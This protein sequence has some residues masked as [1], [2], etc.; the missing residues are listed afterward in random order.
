MS[1]AS[2][3]GLHKDTY[4]SLQ[5][6]LGGPSITTSTDVEIKTTRPKASLTQNVLERTATWLDRAS[7]VLSNSSTDFERQISEVKQL[8]HE[9]PIIQKTSAGIPQLLGNERISIF[10][11][12][13]SSCTDGDTCNPS[14]LKRSLSQVNLGSNIAVPATT[15]QHQECVYF[16]GSSP[17]SKNI[18]KSWST[19][20]LTSL[21]KESGA[22][23]VEALVGFFNYNDYH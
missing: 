14:T 11:T 5:Q 19:N 10:D 4:S 12:S 15:Y 2:S 23:E 6:P 9:G 22:E 20:C 16:S 13:K 7:N 3:I 17:H 21:N 18:K 8:L 1:P